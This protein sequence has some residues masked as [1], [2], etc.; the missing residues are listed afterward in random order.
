MKLLKSYYFLE[1]EEPQYLRKEYYEEANA[2]L[3]PTYEAIDV[4]R[5][6]KNKKILDENDYSDMKKSIFQKGKD[7]REVKRELTSL[8]RQRQ[9]LEPEEA[10]EKRKF[11]TVRRFLGV[12]KALKTEIEQSKLLPAPLIKE[13]AVLIKKLEEE[14]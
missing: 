10:W 13:A 7:A 14:I 3:V 5:L 6:A 12:L 9:E 1:K 2:N 11:S 4:L 8:I